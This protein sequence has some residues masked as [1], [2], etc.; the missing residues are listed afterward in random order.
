MRM[1]G[2]ASR[3]VGSS[4]L[5]L[6]SESEFWST[7]QLRLAQQ[8]RCESVVVLAELGWRGGARGLTSLSSR[9]CSCSLL[10]LLRVCQSHPQSPT[11]S[12]AA[13]PAQSLNDAVL[14]QGAS[15]RPDLAL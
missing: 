2:P 9:L 4:D 7:A 5:S 14:T 11:M 10:D 8:S 1:T 3:V 13:K 6:A 15:S 12:D